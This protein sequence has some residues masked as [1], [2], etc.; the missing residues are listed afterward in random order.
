MMQSICNLPKDLTLTLKSIATRQALHLSLQK[1]IP[2]SVKPVE[3]GKTSEFQEPGG[4]SHFFCR[5]LPD[6]G[7]SHPKCLNDQGTILRTNAC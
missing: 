4:L 1:V 2:S 5:H 6:V 7:L 3:Y